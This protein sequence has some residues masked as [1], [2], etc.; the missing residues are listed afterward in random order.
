M[1]Q[2]IKIKRSTVTAVPS[3]LEQGEI[4]YSTLNSGRLYIGRPGGTSGDIDT[5]GG[6]YF[7]DTIDNLTSSNSLNIAGDVTTTSSSY[8]SSTGVWTINTVLEETGV[9]S[10][11]YGSTS[12]IPV[13]TIDSKGRVTA[14]ST[15]GVSSSGSSTITVGADSGTNDVVTLNTQVLNFSGGTGVDTA[16]TNNT[17]TFNIG[18]DV[19]TTSNVTF[20]NVTVDGTL[21]SD[22]ITA[23]T[24]TA[25]GNVIVQGNL[26]VNGTTTTVNSNTVS[27]GDNIIVL[28]GDE[29]GSPTQN[30]GIE[31]E[32]GTSS[33]VSLQWNETTDTWQTTVDGSTYSNLLTV[34]NFET[35]I[36]SLDGGT[37]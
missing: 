27:V 35:Q 8:N 9:T 10:G 29:S 7:T 16:V 15:V 20:N 4:A 12:E 14:V 26:T 33:N 28:N 18:Q 19:S 34:S 23:S 36:S 32:R 13:V 31:I 37:F 21:S 5:I 2:T 3:S 11:S 17:I 6:K 1:A 25:S 30:A 22:D 24:M